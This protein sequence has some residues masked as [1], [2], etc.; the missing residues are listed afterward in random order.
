MFYWRA[1]VEVMF[2][3]LVDL[4]SSVFLPPFPPALDHPTFNTGNG[5][6][7]CEKTKLFLQTFQLNFANQFCRLYSE[8]R[9]TSGKTGA[10]R[11]VTVLGWHSRALERNGLIGG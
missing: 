3:L 1:F 6:P 2:I 5:T 10:L 7:T 4:E 9:C 8:F 11:G